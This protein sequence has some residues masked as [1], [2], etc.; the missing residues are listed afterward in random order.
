[1]VPEDTAL[2]FMHGLNPYGMA[3]LRRFNESNADLNRNFMFEEEKYSGVPESYETIEWFLNP[4]SSPSRIDMFFP[5]AVYLILRHG[6]TTLKQAIAG[7]QYEY[8][9]G[10]YFGGSKMEGYA[11]PTPKRRA[12]YFNA[13]T[14]PTS[15]SIDSLGRLLSPSS[16]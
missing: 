16:F 3:H 15:C 10:I 5:Q 7:G 2:V 13:A 14:P 11:E 9:K 8:P 12:N 4:Q 6:F 1:M